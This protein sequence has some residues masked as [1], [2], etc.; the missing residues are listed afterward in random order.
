MNIGG[1]D[2]EASPTWMIAK[3]ESGIERKDRTCLR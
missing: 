1:V 2:D 3:I